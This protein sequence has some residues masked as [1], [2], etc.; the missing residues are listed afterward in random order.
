MYIQPTREHFANADKIAQQ[1]IDQPEYI[2]SLTKG[3]KSEF[4]FDIKA[5]IESKNHPFLSVY[6]E[7]GK[8][9]VSTK[10]PTHTDKELRIL[11]QYASNFDEIPKNTFRNVSSADMGRIDTIMIEE[12][13]TGGGLRFRLNKNPD[14][15]HD[16]DKELCKHSHGDLGD[17]GYMGNGK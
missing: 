4:L 8:L 15:L 2:N 13:I 3:L 17:G 12:G 7:D 6:V 5:A 11:I 14:Y 16:I 1:C 10:Y 9:I